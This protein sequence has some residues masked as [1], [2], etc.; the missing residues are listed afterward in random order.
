MQPD[1]QPISDELRRT[2]DQ[3]EKIAKA[4]DD[5]IMKAEPT[6]ADLQ[7]AADPSG[8][9]VISGVAPSREAAIRAG[10]AAEAVVGV[11]RLLNS[12]MIP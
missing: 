5:A 6:I 1:D 3:A 11:R 8:T 12:L 9:V 7:V 2:L 10:K 4:V